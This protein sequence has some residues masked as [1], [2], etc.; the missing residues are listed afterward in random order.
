MASHPV[1]LSGLNTREAITDGLYRA[2]NAFDRND[3][4]LFDSAFHGDDAS[5]E[6]HQMGDKRVTTG[7]ANI[8]NFLL[9]HIGPMNTTHMATNIRIEMQDG[10]DSAHLKALAL[11]QHFRPGTGT[12]LGSQNYFVGGEYSID[13]TKDAKDGLWKI[14]KWVLNV[15]WRQGD[16]TLMHRS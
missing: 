16:P 15:F 11:N 13:L 10:S 6:L 3:A 8:K 2:L 5:F 7:T 1:A 12:E 9:S 4:T 14:N